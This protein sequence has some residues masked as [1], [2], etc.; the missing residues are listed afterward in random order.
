MKSRSQKSLSRAFQ[1]HFS[2][3]CSADTDVSSSWT[4]NI[5][6]T[7]A[8]YGV[9]PHDHWFQPEWIDEERATAERTA[10]VKE[11]VIYGGNYTSLHP[12][13]LS[14]NRAA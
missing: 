11:K 6:S 3:G 1:P 9:I 12:F 5:I 14:I 2:P 10:M 7:K 8:E 4:S 13:T